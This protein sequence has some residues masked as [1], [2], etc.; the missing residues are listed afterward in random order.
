VGLRGEQRERGELRVRDVAAAARPSR[1]IGPQSVAVPS[2]PEPRRHL[3]EFAR[4]VGPAS[5]PEVRRR[6]ALGLAA[7]G[8]LE[9]RGAEQERERDAV[10]LCRRTPPLRDVCV[11]PRRERCV[12]PVAGVEV[13]ERAEHHLVEPR[14]E[15]A[16]VRHP[17]R[18]GQPALEEVAALRDRGFDPFLERR[19]RRGDHGTPTATRPEQR[20]RRAR[21]QDPGPAADL[22]H[23]RT[24]PRRP[25]ATGPRG[26]EGGLV[27][28]A[29]A[30]QPFVRRPRRRRPSSERSVNAAT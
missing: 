25:S 19:L 2:V 29:G 12:L 17:L 1:G 30:R 8:L 7:A 9:A 16:P 21:E 26:P 22:P 15:P 6:P 4:R 13:G 10:G 20:E 14:R 28:G 11:E 3:A 24:V 5:L 27:P 18:S 23:P